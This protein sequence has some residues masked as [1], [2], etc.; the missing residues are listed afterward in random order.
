[1]K[2]AFLIF[3]ITGSLGCGKF[4]A[5]RVP[6]VHADRAEQNADSKQQ[7]NPSG[8]D[9]PKKDRP[10]LDTA[11]HS[12]SETQNMKPLVAISD[13]EIEI[14]T[15][16]VD[17]SQVQSGQNDLS[18]ALERRASREQNDAEK[19]RLEMEQ[20][21][22]ERKE[23]I[24]KV[25]EKY[26]RI[27][28]IVER[29]NADLIAQ[30]LKDADLYSPENWPLNGSRIKIYEKDTFEMF[31]IPGTDD[32]RK[33]NRNNSLVVLNV[34]NKENPFVMF[35]N[36]VSVDSE[37]S[38]VMSFRGYGVACKY[39]MQGNVREGDVL[40]FAGTNFNDK[41]SEELT[42]KQA[43]EIGRHFVQVTFEFK[44]VVQNSN[45]K[46]EIHCDFKTNRVGETT[47]GYRFSDF[48]DNFVDIFGWQ[49]PG[50]EFSQPSKFFGRELLGSQQVYSFEVLDLERLLLVDHS[51]I[52][53]EAFDP[54]LMLMQGI[55]VSTAGAEEF[56][57][58]GYA[59]HACRLQKVEGKITA[60]QKFKNGD[61]VPLGDNPMKNIAT[62]QISYESV[63]G[64]TKATI[65]CLTR[66]SGGVPPEIIEDTFKNVLK[67][68]VIPKEKN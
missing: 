10:K 57:V 35:D 3:G 34:D 59:K 61:I 47:V 45:N 29:L 31:E 4:E 18:Q 11:A 43:W 12:E 30:K 1:M 63:D 14:A 49:L 22:R 55:I 65:S 52:K 46:L 41:H 44:D 15:Y 6:L 39:R 68:G 66:R 58:K 67:F 33:G 27:N 51:E 36:K 2:L 8:S 20:K 37:A 5:S 32:L 13:T 40:E 53:D 28:P 24:Q 21:V 56:I 9:V 19:I 50:G 38:R 62:Y 26:E 42:K 25:K 60:Q 48:L 7:K 17:P 54:G 16:G 64:Q 23:I